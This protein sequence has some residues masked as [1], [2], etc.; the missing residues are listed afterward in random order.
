MHQAKIGV[1]RWSWFR[2]LGPFSL[3]IAALGS[4]VALADRQGIVSPCQRAALLRGDLLGIF[5]GSFFHHGARHAINDIGS[6]LLMGLL[7]ERVVGRAYVAVLLITLPLIPLAVLL[8]DPSLASYCGLSGTVHALFAVALVW[9]WRR[10]DWRPSWGVI[11]LTVALGIKLLQ[12]AFTGQMLIDLEMASQVRLVPAA[13]LIGT[14][15]GVVAGLLRRPLLAR[16]YSGQ[17][18]DSRA[19]SSV[20]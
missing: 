5:G 19:G 8:L 18:R 3:A 12:E 7:Y 9:E 17:S 16:S 1:S 15:C 2:A 14:L 10:A 6:V 4:L 13:H 11:V 20:L